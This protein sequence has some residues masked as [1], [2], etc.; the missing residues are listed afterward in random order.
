MKKNAVLR[1]LYNESV[2]DT[3]A[4]H[5]TSEHLIAW[6]WEEKF[7][8]AII[9]EVAKVLNLDMT[10]TNMLYRHFGVD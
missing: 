1:R 4:L 10:K 7:A 6:A 8:E 5:K 2:N 9:D 3:V